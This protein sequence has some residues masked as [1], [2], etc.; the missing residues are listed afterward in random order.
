MTL[1]PLAYSVADA[2]K[3]AAVS[4]TTLYEAIRRK[5]ITPR[6]CGKKTLILADDLKNWVNNLPVAHDVVLSRTLADVN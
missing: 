6:K 1:Q 5:E 4:R 3:I 2:C